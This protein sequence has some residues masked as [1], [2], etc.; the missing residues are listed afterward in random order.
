MLPHAIIDA[1]AERQ[2]AFVLT[3]VSEEGVPNSIWAISSGLYNNE[4]IVV[5]DNYFD[6]TRANIFDTGVASLLFITRDGVSYQLKG[7][8]SYHTE[9]PFYE[10]MKAVTPP[11]YPGHGAAVLHATEIYSGSERLL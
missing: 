2:P 10:F 1:W 3:T 8:L 9:G 6:K 7:T 11:K 4:H 5:A